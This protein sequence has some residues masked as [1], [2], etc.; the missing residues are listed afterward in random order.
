MYFGMP[1]RIRLRP[2]DAQREPRVCDLCGLADRTLVRSYI[3]HKHGI[4]YSGPWLHPL[5]P[6]RDR[7]ESFPLPLLGSPSGLGYR[8]WLG[9]VQNNTET[10]VR[11]ALVVSRFAAQRDRETRADFRLWAFGYDMANMK[12]RAWLDSTMPLILVRAE[13]REDYEREVARLVLGARQ[14]QQALLFATKVACRRR[15]KEVPGDPGS[16]GPRFWQETEGPF[17]AFLERLLAAL[18]RGDFDPVGVRSDWHRLLVATASRAF[19]TFAA[20]AVEAVD[21]RR[22][23]TAWNGLRRTLYGPK[24]LQVLG[25][26]KPPP[27]S[28]KAAKTIAEVPPIPL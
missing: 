17:Y 18:T 23:A 7:K 25:L 9:L 11:P 12:A 16:V 1:R 2:E 21:P 24:I 15:P 20:G 26:P 8:H 3:T 6:H 28:P 13:H 14:A 19:D 22:I 5:T 4:N 10:G 27:F